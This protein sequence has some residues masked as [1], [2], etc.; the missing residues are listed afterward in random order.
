MITEPFAYGTSWMHRIDP[1]HKI[2]WAT[3]FSVVVSVS[4]DFAA[5]FAAAGFAAVL[6]ALARLNTVALAKRL[7]VAMGFVLLLWAVLPWTFNGEP[8]LHLGP[9]TASREGVAVSAR[10]T[11][12]TVSIL[13]ALMALVATMTPST[14]GHAMGRL[15]VPEKIVYLLLITYRYIFVIEQEYMRLLRAARVRG[16]RPRTNLHTYRTF[17][18]LVGMLF[19]RAWQR[20]DRVYQA[21]RCRGFKGRFYSLQMFSSHDRNGVFDLLLAGMIVVLAVLEW[22]KFA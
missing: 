3:V 21:M 22:I 1:R 5:L 12:K 4:S 11:L 16:F 8:L 9:L 20:A 14:L 19:V 18:Y 10:I 15:R 17:A 2:V 6:V 13:T 7:A